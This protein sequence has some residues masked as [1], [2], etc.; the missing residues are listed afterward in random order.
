MESP[1]LSDGSNAHGVANVLDKDRNNCTLANPVRASPLFGQ[2][3]R[4]LI[5][6]KNIHE[7]NLGNSAG[8]FSV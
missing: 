3:E 5:H 7:V 6:E 1:M 4:D 8:T 2:A